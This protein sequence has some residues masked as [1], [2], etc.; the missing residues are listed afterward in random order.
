[1]GK[2]SLLSQIPYQHW[3]YLILENFPVLIL[4]IVGKKS[5]EV[6][7]NHYGKDKPA[8]TLNEEE[9]VKS[10]VICPELQTECIIF[11][12]LLVKKPEK[13]IALQFKEII[14][15]ELLVTLSPNLHKIA[16][17][18]LTI[19]V[20]TASVEKILSQM[21]LIETSLQNSL[22]EGRLS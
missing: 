18:G 8:F 21:K 17:I 3:P 4:S 2:T 6:L 9:T 15:N 14:I 16:S 22:T 12:F 1:M 5:T 7:L 19:P 13:R 10:A 11:C 20:S